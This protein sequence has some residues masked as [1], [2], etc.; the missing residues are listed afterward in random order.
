MSSKR[1]PIA[2][3]LLFFS[4]A[5]VQARIFTDDKGR[6]IEAELL[7]VGGNKVTFKK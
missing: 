3:V 4:V 7:V 1:F 5:L 6:E 2:L